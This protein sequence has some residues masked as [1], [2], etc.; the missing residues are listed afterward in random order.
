TG[1]VIDANGQPVAGAAIGVDSATGLGSFSSMRES[2]V[3]KYQL[4]YSDTDGRFSLPG[5]PSGIPLSVPL[6]AQKEGLVSSTVAVPQDHS[7]MTLV[8][9][10]PSFSSILVHVQDKEGTPIHDAKVAITVMGS[11]GGRDPQTGQQ[12]RIGLTTG[13]GM[14]TGPNGSCVINELNPA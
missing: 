5:I 11:A 10:D 2:Q 6:R 7:P 3:R 9:G 8:L 12:F 14:V 13:E 4:T 1:R